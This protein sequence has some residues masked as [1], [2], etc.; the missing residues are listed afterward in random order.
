M[1]RLA[2]LLITVPLLIT[3]FI[4]LFGPASRP[5][6]ARA[7]DLP[8]AS[9][10][11]QAAQ[12]IAGRMS[13]TEKIGQLFVVNIPGNV[14]TNTTSLSPIADLIANER[15][16][17]VQISAANGNY[18]Q[19]I[20]LPTQ[21]ATLTN[22]LQALAALTATA[23]LTQS[24][25]SGFVPLFIVTAADAP[26]ALHNESSQ[27][28]TQIPTQLALGATW[29][30]ENAA[31]VGRI[32]G[33]ELAQMGVNVLLG[34]TL[35]VLDVP[36]PGLPGDA[37][38]RVFGGDPFWVGKFGAAFVLGVHGGSDSRVA[39]IAKNFP[40]L[41]SSDRNIDDEIPTVQKS[42]EQLKQ[43]ELAPFFAVTQQ[44]PYDLT[45]AEGLLVSHIRYRGF[46]GNIRASTRPVSL[47]P[48]AYQALMSL[49]PL[50]AWRD[51]GG[52]TFSDS[53]GTR[54]VRRFYDPL[55]KTFNARRIAQE[56]FVAGNDVLLLGSFGLTNDWAE[57]LANIKD[58]LAFFRAKYA[59]DRNFAAS[60][61]AA[62]LRILSLKLKL[63]G[64]AFSLQ[65]A[66][67]NLDA[68][69]QIK[70]NTEDIA[71]IAKDS[72]TLLSPSARDY[73]AV[74]SSP[75]GKDDS[76]VFITDD[77]LIQECEACAPYPAIAPSALQNIALELYGPDTTGQLDPQRMSS[78][79]FN[80]LV[81]FGDLVTPTLVV[82]DGV[83][84]AITSTLAANAVPATLTVTQ[85][86]ITQTVT[87]TLQTAEPANTPTPAPTPDPA[88]VQSAI[89]KASWIVI[90]M[91]DMNPNLSSTVAL[92]Q[93]L[94][95][96][97]DALRDKK[98]IIFA[99][100]APYYLDATEV[101]KATAYF[102]AYS[103]SSAYLR[104]AIQALFGSATVN[105]ELPVS[106]DAVGYSLVKQTEPN[107][108]QLIP[109]IATEVVTD[110]Q[111]AAPLELKINDPL[112]LRAGPI[113]DRNGH[114]VPDNTPVQFTVN[115]PAERVQQNQMGVTLNG[116]AETTIV[117]ERKGTVEIRAEAEPAL[118]SY[119]IRV[120]ISATDEISIETIK[121]TAIPTNTPLPTLAPT[122]TALPAPT[123]VPTPAPP[124]ER[125]TRTNWLAFAATLVALLVVGLIGLA[126]ATNLGAVARWRAVL[127]SITAGWVAYVLY[128]LGSPGTRR[129]EVALG[130]VGLPIIA[131]I[132]AA[133]V[134]AVFLIGSQRGKQ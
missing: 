134:L 54:S 25:S 99:F 72:I 8:P 47:D 28:L 26:G 51:G 6:H 43:I 121:P 14:I 61:D 45:S 80:E 91:L 50:K 115:F 49:P 113:F 82:G 131:A 27:G 133:G 89:N 22:Q 123:A 90:G 39:V 67:V 112:T 23:D 100:S 5:H 17:G 88:R 116:I 71:A 62:L 126:A 64:G 84:A 59:E 107:P 34:P 114:L 60:V 2:R 40:G 77:R 127:I 108:D 65:N 132:C 75:P 58:T 118:R 18:T 111:V 102:G 52:I 122:N 21:V 104:A 35:D 38:T 85:I 24:V 96:R 69:A 57:H 81:A 66:Q 29:K 128:A 109:M 10:F 46:Q 42:L 74:I 63:Y 97:A 15:I 9:P 20:G 48:Q 37:G 124:V 19:A 94:S 92:R 117:I 73:P 106:V 93:F 79:T 119:V 3:F 68:A 103:R 101:S 33:E 12:D 70:P 76:I 53:L 110:T 31:T 36:K 83:T 129:L 120:N 87:P 4:G 55:E 1:P 125:V 105:G 7:Q 86:P 41:G 78:F 16:G 95:Q 30:P 56:A 13:V 44:S 98:V 130:W 11:T 32:V